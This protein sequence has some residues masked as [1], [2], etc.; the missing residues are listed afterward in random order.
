MPTRLRHNGDFE[1]SLIGEGGGLRRIFELQSAIIP[2]RGH[3]INQPSNLAEKTPSATENE[4]NK[5]KVDMTTDFDIDFTV[6]NNP[7]KEQQVFNQ[8]RVIR[9]LGV[10]ESSE[11]SLKD[12][13][14]LARKHKGRPNVEMFVAL[15]ITLPF[16]NV[17]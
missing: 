11:E 2:E 1:T 3:Q 5:A 14:R 13:P 9:G 7:G 4:S 10:D 6:H 12:D 15:F 8:V 17:P 16:N